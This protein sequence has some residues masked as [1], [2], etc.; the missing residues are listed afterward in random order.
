LKQSIP[1]K[2]RNEFLLERPPAGG[3]AEVGFKS[4]QDKGKKSLYPAKDTTTN[5]FICK[6]KLGHSFPIVFYGSREM[7]FCKAKGLGRCLPNWSFFKNSSLES[8]ISIMFW[9][10]GGGGWF[11]GMVRE[12]KRFGTFARNSFKVVDNTAEFG[13]PLR[14]AFT[15][16]SLKQS[17]EVN[18][19]EIKKFASFLKSISSWKSAKESICQQASDLF[20]HHHHFFSS[21]HH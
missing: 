19:G 15:P 16:P 3:T 1:G 12:K 13:C 6:V 8:D 5:P 7:Q 14:C 20:F 21:S 9:N 4:K 11:D 17:V 2:S 10:K 18:R